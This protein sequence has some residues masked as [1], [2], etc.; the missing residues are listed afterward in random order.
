MAKKT[1]APVSEAPAVAEAPKADPTLLGV[2]LPLTVTVDAAKTVF[3]AWK[4]SLL[5]LK[6]AIE[7]KLTKKEIAPEAA[8][9]VDAPVATA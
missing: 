4:A 1:S 8:P 6:T 2:G 7:E 5:A 9:A 3:A